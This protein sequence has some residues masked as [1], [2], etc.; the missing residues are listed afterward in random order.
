MLRQGDIL[1]VPVEEIPE[2]LKDVPRESGR[3]VLAHGEA[4][5]HAHVLEGEAKF[6]ASDLEGRFLLVEEN[7]ELVHDEHDTITVPPGGYE[8]RRQR[9]YEPEE[10][11]L[12]AD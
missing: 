5:G 8:V 9:E 6:L 3:M 1:L 4:T 12:V 7:A 2:G 10:S 11:R